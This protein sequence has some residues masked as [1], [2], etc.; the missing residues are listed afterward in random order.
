MKKVSLLLIAT[1]QCLFFACQ[2]DKAAQSII[3][4]IPS[5]FRNRFKDENDIVA[6]TYAAQVKGKGNKSFDSNTFRIIGLGTLWIIGAGRTNLAAGQSNL[7]PYFEETPAQSEN[8]AVQL[9]K[10]K[11]NPANGAGYSLMKG[12]CMNVENH[13]RL[14]VADYD[15]A[16]AAF[17]VKDKSDNGAIWRINT[18]EFNEVKIIESGFILTAPNGNTLKATIL[19]AKK[20]RIGTQRHGGDTE[21]LNNGIVYHNK[22]YDY[23]TWI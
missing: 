9:L 1:I 5:I 20:I 12:S 17:V 21:R 10:Y 4:D 14:F 11:F 2:Q 6:L 19:G 23:S 7:F 3:S 16:Q 22:R 18:P 15:T 13:Q 8:R